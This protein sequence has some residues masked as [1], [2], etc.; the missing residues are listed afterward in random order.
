MYVFDFLKSFKNY[1]AMYKKVLKQ[2]IK[3]KKLVRKNCEN[4]PC[5]NFYATNKNFFPLIILGELKD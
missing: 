2:Q 3:F 5:H 1:I 4:I